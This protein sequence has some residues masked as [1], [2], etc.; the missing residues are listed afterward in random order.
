MEIC[1]NFVIMIFLRVGSSDMTLM[2]KMETFFQIIMFV[3]EFSFTNLLI[4]RNF[5]L[6]Q[7]IF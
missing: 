2:T 1:I 5:V 7:N 3:E 4:L 6:K